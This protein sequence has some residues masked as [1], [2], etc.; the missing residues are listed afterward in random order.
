M[1]GPRSRTADAL[2]L[3][4]QQLQHLSANGA[5]PPQRQQPQQYGQQVGCPLKMQSTRSSLV[6]P[7]KAD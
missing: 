5:L 7:L 1:S 2:N 3:S 4:Q 6:N